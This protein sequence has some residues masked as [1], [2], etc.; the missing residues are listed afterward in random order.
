MGAICP[1]CGG[2][3]LRAWRAATASDPQ[4]AGRS[5]FEL[6]RCPR[7]GSA[8]TVGAGVDQAAMYEGGTY[9]EARRSLAPLLTPLRRLADRDRARLVSVM[10]A[11]GRVLE[12][13]AGDGHL[14][15][16]MR[17]AG[18]DAW[19]IDPS[20]A[21]C[22]AAERVGIEVRN[23]GVVEAEIEPASQ[24]G[25]VLWHSLEHVDD[26]AGAIARIGGW[27]RPGGTLVVAVP[28]IG[29]LQARIGGDRWF[30][31]DVPRHRTHFTPAG[32]TALLERAGFRVERIRHLLVEQNP[33][34]MWQT[35]LNRLTVQ[36]DFAFRLIKRDVGEADPR[37]RLRDIAVTA[38]AG[39]VL[40]PI[41]VAL[42]VAADLVGR[43]G[44]MVVEA[45]VMS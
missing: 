15:A 35:L 27:L 38:V 20:P 11:G 6:E 23:A 42:E 3:E 16:R 28:N 24:D 19:G 18:L 9:A 10:P 17:A 13:G 4:L 33:L 45:R 32:I 37:T 36:R 31:Q 12:V 43:G 41:A 21:A 26:P 7:C 8:R 1:A 22:A 25:V 30:H 2:A 39:L 40:A 44:S 5:S 34:G 14:V 29:G